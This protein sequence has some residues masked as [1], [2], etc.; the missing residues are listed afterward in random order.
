[1]GWALPSKRT[2]ERFTDDVKEYLNVFEQG[3]SDSRKL[4][5]KTVETNMKKAKNEDGSNKFIKSEIL[6]WKQIASYFG[7]LAQK[8]RKYEG[9]PR[10]KRDSANDEFLS[11][12]DSYEGEFDDEIKYEPLYIGEYEEMRTLIENEKDEIFE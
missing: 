2:M 11:D 5:P 3:I 8:Q 10:Q 7:R 9:S 6:S 4:D 1:M 12:L